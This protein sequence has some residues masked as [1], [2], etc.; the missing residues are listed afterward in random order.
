MPGGFDRP[1]CPG[2]RER[3]RE[4]EKERGPYKRAETETGRLHIGGV[5]TDWPDFF[6]WNCLEEALLVVFLFELLVRVKLHKWRFCTDCS[7]IPWN[8][9]DTIIVVASRL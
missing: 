2:E 8:L 6:L 1:S 3:W 9:L 4:G 5:Q 7:E